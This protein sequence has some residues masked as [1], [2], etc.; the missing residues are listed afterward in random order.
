MEDNQS[1]SQRWD[2]YQ[3]SKTLWFWSLVGAAVLTMIVGFTAGG[4]TT[5]GTALKM[6][7]TSARDARAEL[8]ANLCVEKFVSAADA[9]QNLAKLKETSS[10]QRDSF[11]TDGGWINLAG[12]KRKA[13]GAA[14]LCAEK[15]AAMDAIP[16]RNVSPAQTSG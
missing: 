8:V 16:A 1:V 14:D 6:A 5:G 11:I 9:S 13:P 15:L 7:Q 3:P 10:Y 2:N 12:I 4:W